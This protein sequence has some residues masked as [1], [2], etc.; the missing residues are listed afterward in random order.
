L[1]NAL[2]QLPGR[3]ISNSSEWTGTASIAWTPPI[4]D[5]GMRAL[6]YLDGRLTTAYNT[7]SDLDIEK[8]QKG[9][10]VFN[11][12]IGIH[13]P[14]DGWAVEF[15][16]Q[17]LLNED[18]LQVAFDAP[19]QGGCTTRGAVRGF[20][21]ASTSV[22]TGTRATQLYGAFLGEPR[23]FGITLRAKWAPRPT[24]PAYSPPPAPPPPPPVVEQPAPPAPPPP[25]PPP[26]PTE[27][28]ERGN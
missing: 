19:I 4:G 24:P 16:G 26:P 6:F 27:K 10:S 14:G 5:S 21:A 25:P 20:C 23:T 13:G 2:F 3:R 7:G 1:T 9:F 28:G 22:P 15:W 12:R 18:F 11:G 17:N 8:H